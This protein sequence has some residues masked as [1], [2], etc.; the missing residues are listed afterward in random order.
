MMGAHGLVHLGREITGMTAR[1]H[2]LTWQRRAVVLVTALATALGV[3]VLAGPGAEAAKP[4][5]PAPTAQL[6]ITKVLDAEF[7]LPEAAA[8]GTQDGLIRSSKPFTVEVQSQDLNGDAL[9]QTNGDL[10]VAQ[11]PEI[12]VGYS[13]TTPEDTRRR[14]SVSLVR[15]SPSR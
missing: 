7:T 4:P 8:P 11:G 9:T 5:A 12:R 10:K 6:E 14:R 13:F 15:R 3:V 2:A 1:T